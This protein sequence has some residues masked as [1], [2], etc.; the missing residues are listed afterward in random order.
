MSIRFQ[1]TGLRLALIGL[2]LLLAGCA[3]FGDRADPVE[4]VAAASEPSG[5]E[6]A[7][8]LLAAKRY[9]EALEQ[10]RVVLREEPTRVEAQVGQAEAQLG[11]GSYEEALAGFT[12][13]LEGS[14]V[15]EQSRAAAQQGRGLALFRLGRIQEA[16][17]VLQAVAEADPTR[18]RAWNALGQAHDRRDQFEDAQAAYRQAL[19]AAPNHAGLH[20]NLGFSLLS[21]G[22]HE[23]AVDSFLRAVELDPNLELARAN[24]RLALA[25]LGRYTEALAG[26]DQRDLPEALNN[27]GYIALLRGD[28]E[29]AE[30]DF[31]RALEVS[32]SFF[33]P[34]W[35]N[36]QYL[37][38]LKQQEAPPTS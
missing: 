22:R 12:R 1:A 14:N 32:P 4:A 18:W 6:E 13:V 9:E 30:A 20:N 37:G 7:R 33:E 35:R 11:L 24:L 2:G 21:Q 26:V 29:R 15:P 23:A 16:I 5:L 25:A 3:S 10:F 19:W 31:L 8:R 38:T 28:P 34:A 17:P 36:L 27:I